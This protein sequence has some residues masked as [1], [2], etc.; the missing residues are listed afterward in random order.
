MLIP[1]DENTAKASPST[2]QIDRFAD[3]FVRQRTTPTMVGWRQLLLPH[4]A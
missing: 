4:P 3:E 2:N 1:Q